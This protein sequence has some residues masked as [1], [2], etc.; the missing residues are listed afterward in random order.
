LAG[1]YDGARDRLTVRVHDGGLWIHS[2]TDDEQVACVPIDESRFACRWGVVAFQV[3]DGAA[4][5]LKAGQ[6][7]LSEPFTYRRVER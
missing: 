2:R 1:V 4:V 6:V 7:P 5:S 3:E